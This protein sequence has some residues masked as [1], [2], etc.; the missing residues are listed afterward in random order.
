MKKIYL[1]GFAAL[2]GFSSVAQTAK[3]KFAG[4]DQISSLKKKSFSNAK[5]NNPNQVMATYFTDDFSNAANWTMT[6]AAGAT[7]WTIGTT[8]GAGSFS[9]GPINSTTAANGYALFD[10][11]NGCDADQIAHMTTT[12]SFSTLGSTGVRLT[13]Q[14]F[15][16]KWYDSTRVYVSN[17]GTT[18]TLFP[19][20]DQ[21]VNAN[22]ASDLSPNPE[23]VTINIS[24][25]AANQATVWVRFTFY[26]PASVYG[27]NA[28]CGY[29]WLI[30]DVVVDDLPSIDAA[31]TAVNVPT[32]DC[33]LT[34]T[35]PIS[36]DIMNNGATPITGFGVSYNVNG[37]TAV[38]ETFTGTIAA[39]A[40][41]THTFA[42]TANLS[43]PGILQ[44]VAAS[45]TLAGDGNAA[46]D[47]DT[48]YTANL[49]PNVDTL[50]ED[51]DL[52][53]ALIG[54]AFGGNNPAA[55]YFSGNQH[56]AGGAASLAFNNGGAITTGVDEW[57]FSNCVTLTAG[58]S[59]YIQYWGNTPNLGVTSDAVIETMIGM[60]NTSAAQTQSLGK[61]TLFST[62]NTYVL[63]KHI[64]TVPTTG[65]YNVGFHA[66]PYQNTTWFRMD[67]IVLGV[68]NTVGVKANNA[69]NAIS[70]YPNPS[71]GM[72]NLNVANAN[73]QVE[74]FSVIGERVYSKSQLNKG[75][76]TMDL[77]SLPEGS[78][79]VRILSG[80]EVST[81]KIAI[82][83]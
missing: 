9:L 27:S 65:T 55:W 19:V 13:F 24:S 28:G 34:S 6:Q 74:V 16:G 82:S 71:N 23:T 70:I 81:K 51:L 57:V 67:D 33:D 22:A 79:I 50:Y 44:T 14:Q 20:N 54:W 72:F 78:Y 38:N 26:S 8:P 37:G 17:N 58:T 69:N 2:M 49:L 48:A 18:W 40:T 32:P 52:Q 41:A 45:V 46:N 5:L 76:N 3:H 4:N 39:G 42:G 61:D 31:V 7:A 30:D 56:T 43:T 59:Y 25:V 10:S 77:S 15:Y 80:N 11:D 21:Y 66:T 1:L 75:L 35:E 83:K 29:N 36:I 68:N 64:F 73:S 53:T 60:D 63:K 62:T 12:N 47:V